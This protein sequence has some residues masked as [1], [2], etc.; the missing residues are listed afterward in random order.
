MFADLR[1][2][3]GGEIALDAE[4]FVDSCENGGKIVSDEEDRLCS[5]QSLQKIED[6]SGRSGIGIGCS[7]IKKEEIGV[8]Q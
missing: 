6:G 2:L 8:I 7:L 3:I 1:R 5:L 4:D